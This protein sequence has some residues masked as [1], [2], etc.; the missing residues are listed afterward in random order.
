MA[1][2]TRRAQPIERVKLQV[3]DHEIHAEFK[4]GQI[5]LKKFEVIQ[6]WIREILVFVRQY[7]EDIGISR[8]GKLLIK[9]AQHPIAQFSQASKSLADVRIH[10]DRIDAPRQRYKL[11]PNR[12]FYFPEA[13]ADQLRRALAYELAKLFTPTRFD[14]LELNLSQFTRVAPSRTGDRSMRGPL[15]GGDQEIQFDRAGFQSAAEREAN[16]IAAIIIEHIDKA[17]LR[18]VESL[19]PLRKRGGADTNPIREL[20]LTNLPQLFKK[21]FD[22]KAVYV[23]DAYRDFFDFAQSICK[24]LGV[25]AYCTAYQLKEGIKR[26]KKHSGR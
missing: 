7:E 18:A 22:D 1:K 15:R 4:N 26:W 14:H 8:A 25:P 16:P 17:F 12:P 5:P 19:K 23:D 6:N 11:D 9:N 21:I 2:K 24:L 13:G 3:S 10:L 20:I